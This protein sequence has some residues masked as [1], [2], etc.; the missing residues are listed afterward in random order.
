[1]SV[2][3]SAQQ[4]MQ[5]NLIDRI[6]KT[7]HF[8]GISP[9]QLQL[10]LI[11]SILVKYTDTARQTFTEL[12]AIGVHLAIDDFGTGYSSLSYLYHFPIQTLKIDRL[13]VQDCD[14]N[15]EKLELMKVILNLARNLSTGQK[16]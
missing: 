12:R 15:S 1:M 10:E 5:S 7:L 14:Q 9:H 13:F 3:L 6:Q 16:L 2:N 8:T 4:L 11:E